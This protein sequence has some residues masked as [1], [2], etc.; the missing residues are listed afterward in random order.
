MKRFIF[1]LLLLQPTFSFPDSDPE[2]NLS[3]PFQNI[4]A[5]SAVLF[6]P[7]AL[8]QLH[9]WW[10]NYSLQ[11]LDNVALLGTVQKRLFIAQEPFQPLLN[12][13]QKYPVDSID[14]YFTLKHELHQCVVTFKNSDNYKYLVYVNTLDTCIH[15]LKQLHAAL[16][17]R[18][19]TFNNTSNPLYDSYTHVYSTLG[20]IIATFTNVFN[21]LKN[22]DEFAQDS[23]NNLNNNEE[24]S[25]SYL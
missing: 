16:Q 13:V 6:I 4:A 5:V 22:T 17:K 23:V 15:D 9:A 2:P 11:R 1:C 7:Y 8:S 21:Y 19:D 18:I 12:L 14:A 25:P 24:Y 20:A 3:I 10:T